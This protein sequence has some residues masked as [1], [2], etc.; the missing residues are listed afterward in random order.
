MPRRALIMMA[1][2]L[3]GTG[4]ASA[5]MMFDTTPSWDGVSFIS[6]WGRAGDVST[7]TYG[8]TFIAPADNVLQSFTFYIKGLNTGSSVTF[9]A[10]V[11][12]WSGS[13]FGG[14]GSQGAMGPA[15]FTSPD[16]T[17]VDNGSFQAV[18]VNTGGTLLDAGAQY[19]ALFTTSDPGSLNANASSLD[20]FAWGIIPP[21]SQVPNDG[22]GGFNYYNNATS[23]QLNTTAWDDSMD[24]G[25]LAWKADF[26]SPSPEPSSLALLGLGLLLCAG[27]CW[28]RRGRLSAHR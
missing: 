19:V 2:M 18:T 7:A 8:E 25:E 26:T 5:D 22:G 12:A 27:C 3:G 16:M 24:L 9:Q 1:A 20:Q 23:G 17:F 4:A 14:N 13:L 11:Y 21:P 15:L 10:D 6:P 28:R